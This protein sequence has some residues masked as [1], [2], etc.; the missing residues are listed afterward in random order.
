MKNFW[1]EIRFISESCVRVK[2]FILPLIIS[3]L[4][5]TAAFAGNFNEYFFD[6]K[7]Q[8]Y[9]FDNDGL[10]EAIIKKNQE[11]IEL[12]R[13][14][15]IDFTQTDKEGYTALERAKMTKDVETLAFVNDVLMHTKRKKL[16]LA[17]NT[18][19]EA[20]ENITNP[21]DL[22]SLVKANNAEELKKTAAENK[23]L[24]NLSAEGLTPLHYAVFNDNTQIVKILLE[25]GADVN[26][27]TS[28]GLTPLDIAVLN[29]QK[30]TAKI[31]LDFNGGMSY[32]LAEELEGFGCK[33]FYNNDYDVYNAGF[34]DIFNAMS[35]AKEELDNEVKD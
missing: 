20:Q 29:M 25:A 1:G 10:S 22:F 2:N 24:N 32:S 5:Q 21:Y 15:G 35:I 8:G 23:D 3:L 11:A 7:M 17:A 16:F 12:F 28:D 18:K 27:K 6:L 19:P 31:I 4:F 14:A 13:K 30:E 34:E 33:S 26:K 9:S